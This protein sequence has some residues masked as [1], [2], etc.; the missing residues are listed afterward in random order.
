MEFSAVMPIHNESKFIPYSLPAVYSLDPSE[1][2]LIF[3]RCTDNSKLIS[4]KIAKK[5]NKEHLTRFIELKNPV[6]EY[7]FRTAFVRRYAFNL[8]TKDY[9]LNVD[10]D[11]LL[12][13]KI[14]D[15][16]K[17]IKDYGLIS[18]GY[19]DYPFT[20]QSIIRKLISKLIPRIGF[21]GQYIFNKKAWIETEDSNKVKQIFKAEDTHLKEAMEK[22]YNI[23]FIDTKS[24]HLK[25]SET[26]QKHYMR[27]FANW[28]VKR[29]NLFLMLIQS[30]IY[31]RPASFVGY[32][33][34][35][36]V[37]SKNS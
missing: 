2:I 5:H 18:F 20:F 14:K 24:L 25:P 17:R 29:K 11:V 13:K 3:D 35:R 10:S 30:I 37:Y 19:L 32:Y 4:K 33:Y 27:G 15:Y 23:A 7:N 16:L 6:S 12:D 31:L 36:F 28:E 34:S 21:T 8:A 26:K 9:I 22:K 1:V